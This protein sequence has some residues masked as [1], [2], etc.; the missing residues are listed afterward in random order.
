MLR[1]RTNRANA[2]VEAIKPLYKKLEIIRYQLRW[3]SIAATVRNRSFQLFDST[4]VFEKQLIA[5]S[6]TNL[7]L[8]LSMHHYT[9]SRKVFG[10]FYSNFSLTFSNDGTFDDL[11]AIKVDDRKTF[12][13]NP[14]SRSAG[15]QITG[16]IGNFESFRESFRV[17]WD[18]YHFIDPNR[19]FAIHLNPVYFDNTGTSNLTVGFLMGFRDT[20]DTKNIINAELFYNMQ[21]LFKPDGPEGETERLTERST[22]GI[23]FTTPIVFKTKIEKQ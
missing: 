14:V 7:E 18:Y 8:G 12:L 17:S 3:F 2:T 13:N 4:Q 21:D 1:R 22:L 11:V 10:S 23:R 19:I 16:Y 9:V 6:P 15:N 5:K 20:K